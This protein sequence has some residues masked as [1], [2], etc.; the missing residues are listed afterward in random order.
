MAECNV[1]TSVENDTKVISGRD[2]GSYD[3]DE[4]AKGVISKC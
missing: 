4:S 2:G 3:G 1:F